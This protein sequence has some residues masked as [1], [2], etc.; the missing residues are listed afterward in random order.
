MPGP[1]VYIFSEATLSIQVVILDENN[2]VPKATT[3]PAFEPDVAFVN[4][5]IGMLFFA[6]NAVNLWDN[7]SSL[8]QQN[9]KSV[10]ADGI[11]IL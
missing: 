1:S 6:F 3:T 7:V 5:T 9:C 4:N 2:E 10:L 11:K 8:I